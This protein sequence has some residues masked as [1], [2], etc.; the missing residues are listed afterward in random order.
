M[1]STHAD[2]RAALVAYRNRRWVPTARL[3][4]NSRLLGFLET[5]GGAGALG[6]DAFFWATGQLGVARAVFLDA[7]TMQP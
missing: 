6:R 3:L 7:A 5:Q 1:G 4:A 2:V